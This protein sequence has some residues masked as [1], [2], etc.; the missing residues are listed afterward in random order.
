MKKILSFL[1]IMITLMGVLCSCRGEQG[2][3]GEQGVQGDVGPQGQPGE[4][5]LTP[6]IGD[7][8]NWW[9]GEKDTGVSAKGENG[10]ST[11]VAID[12]NGYWVIN[13]E[14]T[15]YKAEGNIDYLKSLLDKCNLN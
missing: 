9:I 13:N 8:G 10:Q 1:L 6:F 3:Q 2:P 11:S 7:N 15:S 14:V 5:G 12:E 4:D